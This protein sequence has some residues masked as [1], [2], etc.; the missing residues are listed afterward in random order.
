MISNEDDLRAAAA[1][2][3]PQLPADYWDAKLLIAFLN[4]L[5]DWRAGR[6]SVVPQEAMPR[7]T[8]P[9]KLKLVPKE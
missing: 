1:G 7:L 6:G 5:N 9:P 3:M 8:K 2:L 4:Q